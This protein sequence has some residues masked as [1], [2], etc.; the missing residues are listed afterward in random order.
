M[1]VFVLVLKKDTEGRIFLNPQS[2][3]LLCGAAS[4]EQQDSLLAEVEQQLNTPYGVMML[5]PSY[6]KMREDVGRV[7]QKSAGSAENGSIYNHA[8]AFYAYSLYQAGKNDQAFDVLSKMLPTEDDTLVRGQLPIY[9]P[10]YY[11]GAYFQYPEHAGKSSHLIN[12]GTISWVYRCIN[13]ELC[14]LKGKA[15]KLVVA[16]K[17]P[18]SLNKLSGTRYFQGAEYHFVIEKA[19][20]EA[21]QVAL[22]GVSQASNEIT[23][24]G[25]G[26]FATLTIKSAKR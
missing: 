2:W 12:T 5:A 11:R 13:E 15:G 10:N 16:P 22:D 4:V 6:T 21:V 26:N 17:L 7:T 20:V 23:H 9:I 24:I 1:M 14:G 25:A 8:A 18:S 19:D 3:A